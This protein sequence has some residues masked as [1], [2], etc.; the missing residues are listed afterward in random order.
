MKIANRAR[1]SGNFSLRCNR[2]GGG[3]VLQA[4]DDFLLALFDGQLTRTENKK[5]ALASGL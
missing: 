3:G 2:L 1:E 5:P 4:A